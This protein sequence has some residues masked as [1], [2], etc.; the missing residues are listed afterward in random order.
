MATPKITIIDTGYANLSSG[1]IAFDKIGA[2]AKVSADAD[3]IRKA[4]KLVLPG[5]GT[6]S[7]AMAK[8]EERKL[9]DLIRSARQPLLGICLGMQMLSEIS[10]EN[11]REE[12][13][14]VKCLGVIG[15]RVSLMKTGDLRLPHMGWNQIEILKD[16]PLFEGIRN[17]SFFYFVH[18]YAMNLGDWTAASCTY[19][20]SFTAVASSGNFMG[21]QFHPEKSGAA[22]SK[23]LKNFV[24]MQL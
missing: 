15:S 13:P 2:D 22:G 11:L 24:E 23:L 21:T 16:H 6:A 19:G 4:D 1:K 7:A 12:D 18:S 10:E 3:D 9:P 14:E 20:A 17:G 8:L 5:V